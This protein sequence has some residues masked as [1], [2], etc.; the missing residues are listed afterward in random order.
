MFIVIDKDNDK[1]IF[2]EET[3]KQ[4]GKENKEAEEQEADLTKTGSQH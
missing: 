3:Y 4:T 1:G 2:G